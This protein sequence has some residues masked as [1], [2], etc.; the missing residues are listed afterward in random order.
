M[1][2]SKDQD[3]EIEY[4]L[5]YE[6]TDRGSSMALL[7]TKLK[8]QNVEDAKKESQKFIADCCEATQGEGISAKQ[9]DIVKSVL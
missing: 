2:S 6:L 5:L 1:E 3:F 9:I 7:R 8:A 4:Y